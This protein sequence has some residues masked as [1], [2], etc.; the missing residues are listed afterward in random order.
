MH[1]AFQLDSSILVNISPEAKRSP[2]L[3]W[4]LGYPCVHPIT[5]QLSFNGMD[6]AKILTRRALQQLSNDSHATR[7]SYSCRAI[8]RA[9]KQ[10]SLNISLLQTSEGIYPDYPLDLPMC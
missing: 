9:T 4:C 5:Q 3:K 8:A 2:T 7:Q 1:F 10:M 6:L